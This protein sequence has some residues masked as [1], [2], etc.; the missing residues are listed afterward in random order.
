MKTCVLQI[1]GS[2]RA[3]VLSIVALQSVR[4]KNSLQ[5]LRRLALGV[6]VDAAL[7]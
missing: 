6:A 5:K 2:E 7:A 4:H 1:Q 3:V